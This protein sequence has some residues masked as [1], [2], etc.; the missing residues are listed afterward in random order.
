[1]YNAIKI[2]MP[3][4]QEASRLLT[5]L[6]KPDQVPFDALKPFLNGGPNTNAFADLLT[7]I[8]ETHNLG[9][10]RIPLALQ[11]WDPVLANFASAAVKLGGEPVEDFDRIGALM[12]QQREGIGAVPPITTRS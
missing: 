4:P 5:H 3:T 9:T 8:V 10:E 1:V 11:V 12:Q 2:Y 7:E 6:I